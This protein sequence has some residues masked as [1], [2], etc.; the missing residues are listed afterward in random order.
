MKYLHVLHEHRKSII[1]YLKGIS[2]NDI[3]DVFRC[4][5]LLRFS[6]RVFEVNCAT[7]GLSWYGRVC[8]GICCIAILPFSPRLLINYNQSLVPT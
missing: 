4:N 7:S 3:S 6:R 5:L 2:L 1:T 8:C